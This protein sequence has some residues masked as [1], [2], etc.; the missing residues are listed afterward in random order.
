MCTARRQAAQHHRAFAIAGL[1]LHVGCGNGLHL[2]QGAL[3][4]EASLLGRGLPRIPPIPPE[5]PYD[6]P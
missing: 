6:T 5:C 4:G 3:H 1:L 2:G